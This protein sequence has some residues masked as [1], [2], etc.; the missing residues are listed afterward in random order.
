MLPWQPPA[1]DGLNVRSSSARRCRWARVGQGNTRKQPQTK[2]GQWLP[3][4]RASAKT[5]H[6]RKRPQPLDRHGK[7][8]V[9]GSSPTP[10]SQGSPRP[11][12]GFPLFGPLRLH[13]DEWGGQ[14]IGQHPE[15]LM[16]RKPCLG[17]CGRLITSG[18]YCPRC[19]K[20]RQVVRRGS[21]GKQATFRRRTLAKTEGRCARCGRP[22]KFAHH[23]PPISEGGDPHEPG[24]AL[25][26]R[27]HGQAHR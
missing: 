2:S 18:S 21:Y 5:R 1:H 20:T 9:V 14:R 8:G 19:A 24:E 22:A 3:K 10:G 4:R 16:P 11:R 12:G 23:D 7:E 15:A 26:R 6:S 13:L 27:C 25:C 17:G